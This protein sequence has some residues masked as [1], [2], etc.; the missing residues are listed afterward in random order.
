MP[1]SASE[2]VTIEVIKDLD[3]ETLS[4][5]PELKLTRNALS[6]WVGYKL[7]SADVGD[8]ADVLTLGLGIVPFSAEYVKPLSEDSDG[9]IELKVKVKSWEF[10]YKRTLNDD[11]EGKVTVKLTLGF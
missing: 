10:K 1:I 11:K 5:E 4:F 2:K 3:A 6:G 8:P 7:V 9:T